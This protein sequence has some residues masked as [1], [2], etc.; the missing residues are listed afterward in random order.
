MYVLYIFF[1]LK[2]IDHTTRFRI[3]K[4]ASEFLSGVV[5]YLTREVLD[6]SGQASYAHGKDIINPRHIM[7]A[8]RGDEVKN[9]SS[10]SHY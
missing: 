5:D 7:L 6:L 9:F 4:K 3:R 1:V 8:I 10:L 2:I